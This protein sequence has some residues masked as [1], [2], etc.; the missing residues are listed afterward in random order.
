MQMNIE[1]F[2]AVHKLIWNTVIDNASEGECSVHF[3]KLR[4]IELAYEKGILNF[5]ESILL[6]HNNSCLLCASSKSCIECPLKSCKP[7]G[8]LYGRV[9]NERDVKAMVEIRDIVD[10]PPFTEL[11]VITLNEGTVNE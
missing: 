6:I 4:G 5:S 2:K 11:S 7:G 3:C 1:R 10:K 8:S 9:C